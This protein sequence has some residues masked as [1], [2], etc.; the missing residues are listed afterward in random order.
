MSDLK[1]TKFDF[2]CGSV[3]YP[4]RGAYSAPPDRLTVFKEPTYKGI[5]E[6]GKKSRGGEGC[7]IQVGT[8]DAAVEERREREKKK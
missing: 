1:C 8:L 3:R 7:P 4:A 6:G 5:L 2:R